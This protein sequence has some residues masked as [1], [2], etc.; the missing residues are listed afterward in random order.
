MR[1]VVIVGSS[2]AAVRAAET[3]R[4]NG[5][6]GTITVV[7]SE[8]GMPHD[9]PP[10]S[11]KYLSGEVDAERIALRKPEMVDA[12]D[13][14]WRL[15]SAAVALDTAAKTISLADGTSVHYDGLIIATGGDARTLPN[16]P[17]IGGVHTLRT[18]NDADALKAELAP[19]RKFVV[20]GAGFIGLE[21]AATAKQL[22][23]DVTVLEGAPAPLIRGLGAE[24]GEAIAR[25][26]ERNGVSIRCAVTIDGIEQS[27]GHVT[28]VRLGD[29]AIIDADVV[30]VGIGVTPAVAW[31]QGS[32]LTLDDGVVCDANLNAGVPGVYAAGD[33]LR[34]PNELFAHV[35]PKMRVEHWTNA[36]EQGAIAAQN[37]LAESRGEPL[38]AY[39][40]VPF[41]WSDQFDARIQF[42]GRSH[43][44][45]KVTV[46]AGSVDEGRFAAMYTLENRVIAV[47][48]VTMPKMVMPSRVL[49][50]SPTTTEQALAHFERLKNPPPPPAKPAQ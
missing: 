49:L 11:K 36:A 16:I 2:L 47:L 8:P 30:L 15:G 25:I 26:H 44:D 37:L 40:A 14:T 31:L 34:W 21:A 7:G 27:D 39:S 12:L 42:I 6:E 23:A 24:M 50:M 46:V 17:M 4:Q 41:F 38:T 33:L 43:P 18:K 48:G 32:G 13:I 3:L 28:A 19:G 20:I 1:E 45:A 5:H 29:G 10:L 9:R 22:G 35:E